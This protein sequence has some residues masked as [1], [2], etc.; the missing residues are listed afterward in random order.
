[1][2]T[3]TTRFKHTILEPLDQLAAAHGLSRNAFLEYLAESAIRDGFIPI[4]PNEG[5]RAVSPSGAV[6]TMRILDGIQTKGQQAL[7]KP[8]QLPFLQ[9]R[10]A[11]NQGDWKRAKQLLL[12]ARFVV[13]HIASQEPVEQS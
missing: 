6:V 10:K 9:A 4:Q 5:L 1:M 11:A 7:A 12:A 8:E 13:T 3:F 2:A